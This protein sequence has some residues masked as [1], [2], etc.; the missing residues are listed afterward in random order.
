MLFLSAESPKP[1]RI[2]GAFV[3]EKEV[4]RVVDWLKEKIKP[5]ERISEE[6]LISRIEEMEFVFP[7]ETET[8]FEDPLFEEAKRIV[9][10]AQKASASLLQRRLR[11]GYARAARLLDLLEQKGI[12]GPPEGAKPRKVYISRED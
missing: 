3:S 5:I 1:K 4:K 2:Q 10:E 12:V 11:I 9:I 6:D 8:F 7:E